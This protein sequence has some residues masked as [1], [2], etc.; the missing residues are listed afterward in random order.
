MVNIKTYKDGDRLILVV[1]N[2]VG[3][4]AT[5][6]NRFVTELLGIEEE[7]IKVPNLTPIKVEEE[8]I[9]NMPEPITETAPFAEPKETDNSAIIE[10]LLRRNPE[11][12]TRHEV[13]EFYEIYQKLLQD[14]VETLL[15]MAGYESFQDFIAFADEDTIKDGYQALI[16][17]LLDVM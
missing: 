14:S 15:N 9:P 12:A 2:C 16:Q 6:V 4:T 11:T 1:E 5:K 7:P 17:S 10:D 3:E 8:P 13:S